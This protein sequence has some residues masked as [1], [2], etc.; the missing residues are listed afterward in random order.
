MTGNAPR[1]VFVTR[2]TD[3]ERLIARH[4]TRDQARYFLETRGQRIEEAE[5]RHAQFAEALRAARA[6]T[7]GDWRQALAKRTDLDRF[8]FGPEDVVVAVGQDGLVANVAKYLDGQPVLGVNPSPDLYDGVLTRAPLGGLAR[9]LPACAAGA[10]PLE[11]RTMV[12]ATLDS[13][14]RLFALNEIFIGHRSHQSA[15]YRIEAGGAAEN[16]SSSGLIVASGTGAT[17]WARSI[18]EATGAR[19]PLAPTESAVAYYVREPFPSVATGASL[20]AGRIEAGGAL[21]VASRMNDG[22]VVFAD[23]IEQDFLAFDWGRTIR[24][25]ASSRR[26]NLVLA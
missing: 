9:L 14:E 15:R 8:L 26:L 17:G 11:R 24:V 1:A 12:E 21:A 20:R 22:G 23:G 6:A 19:I 10:A 13:G 2:E 18:A 16:Q 4:A 5:R 3:Y 25:A 7:P